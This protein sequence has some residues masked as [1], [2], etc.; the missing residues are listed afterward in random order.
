M[1]NLWT[2]EVGSGVINLARGTTKETNEFEK[3]VSI[4]FPQAKYEF[5]VSE[6]AKG[7]RFEYEIVVA[8]D[9]TSVVPIPRTL[10]RQ[11]AADRAA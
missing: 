3:F 2:G 4:R 11:L 10:A 6:V 9:L 1:P 7:V 8:H 5:T